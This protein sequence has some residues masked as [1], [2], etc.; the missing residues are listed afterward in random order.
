[1]TSR[2]STSLVVPISLLA[3]WYLFGYLLELALVKSMFG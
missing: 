3:T 1:M 2:N